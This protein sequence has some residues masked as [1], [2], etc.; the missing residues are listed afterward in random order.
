MSDDTTPGEI[1]AAHDGLATLEHFSLATVIRSAI[2][3][4][5][6]IYVT[7][8]QRPMVSP[9]MSSTAPTVAGP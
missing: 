2:A 8:G 9:V 5:G 4:S 1:P 6:E 7:D 3:G